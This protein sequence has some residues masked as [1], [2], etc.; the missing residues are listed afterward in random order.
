M[1][2]T[3]LEQYDAFQRCYEMFL[4]G[5]KP[6][7]I[8]KELDIPLT[9]VKRN[10]E[11]Y[12]QA[13]ISRTEADPDYLDRVAEN[14]LKALDE[15][16]LLL[17]E[18]WLLHDKA[19]E[20]EMV[21]SQLNALK[22][23]DAMVDRKAKLLQLMGARADGGNSAK[24]QRLEQVNEIVTKVLKETVSDCAHCKP[25]VQIELARAFSLLDMQEEQED[26]QP[27]IE[28]AEIV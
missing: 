23:L 22:V 19:K 25:K 24:M 14:T 10:I 12:K 9:Q 26:P 18:A 8:A 6:I 11:E 20:F 21:N 4:K 3:V 27:F 17:R 15:M 16:D 7:E 13:I 5:F 2:T 28:E 1:A